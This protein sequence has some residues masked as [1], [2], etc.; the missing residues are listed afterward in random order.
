MN[1]AT[2]SALDTWSLDREIVLTRIIDAPVEAVFQAWVDPA[3]FCQ[4]F[5]PDGF[6]CEVFEHD[7]RS[8]GRSCFDMVVTADGTVFG[9]R[10]DFLEVIE[11]Q[12]IVADHG[13]DIENDPTR[14]RL[15]ITFD[16]QSDGR[17]V[18]TLRQLHP[19]A[20]RRADVIGFGA[21]ALGMQT[22]SKLAAHVE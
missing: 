11:N 8:G 5:G 4:W 10:M 19:T 18:L 6:T 20:Q 7:V 9:N 22:L 16:S 12:R 14:F 1:T 3:A 13:N 2:T 15:T 17:T 21:V